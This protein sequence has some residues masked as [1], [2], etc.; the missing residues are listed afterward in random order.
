MAEVVL[1]V[2]PPYFH[3]MPM[4]IPFLLLH[5]RSAMHSS[6][7]GVCVPILYPCFPSLPTLLLTGMP[8]QL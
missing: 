1:P 2:L 4:C 7:A 5:L 8:K 3:A 6:S